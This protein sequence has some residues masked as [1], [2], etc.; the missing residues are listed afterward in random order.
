MQRKTLAAVSVAVLLAVVAAAGLLFWRH[1]HEPS[2][3]D[4]LTLYGNVDIRQVSLAFD[5]SDRIAEMRAEEGDRVQ[6][7]QVL[8]VLDTRTLRLQ[9]AQAEAQ[10]GV[11]EQ[12]L[13]ALRHGSRPEEVARAGAQV[14]AAQAEVERSRLLLQRLEGAAAQTG[15]RAVS[16]LD[17]DNAAAQLRVAQAQRDAQLQAQRLA[18][19]GPRREDIARAEAQLRAARA[20]QAL[21]QH[22]I[23]QAELRAPQAAVVRSR[24]LEPGDMASPQRPAYVLALTD[25]KWVRAYVDETGLGRIRP[26]MAAPVVTDSAPA[27]PIAGRV[28][29][30]SSVAEFTPKNVQTEELRTSLVYEVRILV[31]DAADG[32]R[33][34]MPATVRIA[35]DA[36][37]RAPR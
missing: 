16:R 17:L 30:I 33:L 26:G 31:E 5:G 14:A 12:A 18:Q 2:A 11:L 24:L 32:L 22:R 1:A 10:V 28:G 3:G 19:I 23:D 21:L 9:R 37:Q 15:G 7:G 8:A 29:F 36:A 34:G 13:L 4:G 20:E 27:V 25:P 35:T 6:A